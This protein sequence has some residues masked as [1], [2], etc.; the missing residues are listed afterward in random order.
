[1]STEHCC[2]MKLLWNVEFK[3][4]SIVWN[5]SYIETCKLPSG[6]SK[7][8]TD[9]HGQRASDYA[10]ARLQRRRANPSARAF[11][12]PRR[13]A[14]TQ[15]GLSRP[16][17]GERSAHSG[18]VSARRG[19]RAPPCARCPGGSPL[20]PAGSSTRSSSQ[21]ALLRDGV[22]VEAPHPRLPLDAPGEELPAAGRRGRPGGRRGR[23][24]WRWGR[25]WRRRSNHGHTNV[26]LL[27]LKKKKKEKKEEIRIAVVWEMERQSGDGEMRRDMEV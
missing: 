15:A 25:G 5:Y 19:W 24:R 16:S 13:P 1:M 22:P 23:W 4:N 27:F 11:L 9:Q 6:T 10:V 7:W 2:E 17:W 8:C 18:A 21:N 12:P 20:A 14:R 26:H 3:S